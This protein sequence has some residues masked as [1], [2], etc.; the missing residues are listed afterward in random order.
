MKTPEEF[1]YALAGV[2]D[3]F[4]SEDRIRMPTL[5]KIYNRRRNCQAE[6]DGGT[7]P[8]YVTRRLQ[9]ELGR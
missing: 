9:N 4:P 3:Y 1:A 2:Y 8:I 6:R 7:R 5:N